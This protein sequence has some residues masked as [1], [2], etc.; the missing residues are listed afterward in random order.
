[1]KKVSPNPRA[2]RGSGRDWLQRRCNQPLQRVYLKI[3]KLPTSAAAD[4]SINLRRDRYGKSLYYQ[5]L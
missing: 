5:K 1:M 2:Q 3:V 4:P